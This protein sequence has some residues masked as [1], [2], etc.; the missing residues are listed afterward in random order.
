[1]K[2]LGHDARDAADNRPPNRRNVWCDDGLGRQRF[3]EVVGVDAVADDECV[4]VEVNTPLAQA[5][6]HGEYDVGPA[7][8]PCFLGLDLLPVR[9]WKR[10][11][12]VIAVIH[13]ERRVEALDHVDERR[14]PHVQDRLVHPKAVEQMPDIDRAESLESTVERGA[15]AIR[16]PRRWDKTENFQ[17]SPG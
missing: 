7:Q 14:V 12:F 9:A 4:R 13:R 5:R 8:E 2:Y 11:V 6:R 15:V 1:M 17:G 3:R 10:A 16:Q